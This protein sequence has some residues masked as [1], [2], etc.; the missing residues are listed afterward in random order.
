MSLLTLIQDTANSVGITAPTV[1]TTSTDTNIINLLALAQTS[2]KAMAKDYDWQELTSYSGTIAATGTVLIGGI[3]TIFGGAF[4]RIVN[5]T[6]W[7]T[8]TRL[9]VDGPLTIQ[10]WQ[11]FKASNVVG[12]PY[13][14]V[15]YGGNLYIGPTAL[16]SGDVLTC[17]YI[18]KYWCQSSAAVGQTAWAADDDTAVIPEELLK[19][20]LIWRW[21]QKNGLAYAEDMET[22]QAEF[23]KYTAQNTPARVL[24]IG[25]RNILYPANIPE[26]YWPGS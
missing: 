25:G 5:Q 7:D 17:Y 19:L 15:I 24:F 18:S 6:L 3:T 11:Q 4:D 8:T 1:V 14:F 23:E 13:Q 21:K 26:G 10:Q 16:A 9:P 12:P 20:D 2:G 22:A